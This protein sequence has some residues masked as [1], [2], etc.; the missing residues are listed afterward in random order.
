[1]ETVRIRPP[2]EFSPNLRLQ[3]EPDMQA[4]LEGGASGHRIDAR[5]EA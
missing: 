5:E 3:L 1:M 2:E 4:G